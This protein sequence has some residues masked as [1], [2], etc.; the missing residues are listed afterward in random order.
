M[1]LQITILHPPAC[2]HARKFEQCRLS[3]SSP[4]R[5]L[6]LPTVIQTTSR[7]SR[8]LSR[9]ID[10]RRHRRPISR[11]IRIY[12]YSWAIRGMFSTSILSLR[13][14]CLLPVHLS[15]WFGATSLSLFRIT[16]VSRGRKIPRPDPS[17]ISR[18]NWTGISHGLLGIFP[19]YYDIRRGLSCP[20]RLTVENV[21]YNNRM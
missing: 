4:V 2:K 16:I 3:F 21:E 1:D 9:A 8:A 5:S 13:D 14:Y 17:A 20:T 15:D 10:C 11:S 19:C 6:F 12:P 7:Y 18:L